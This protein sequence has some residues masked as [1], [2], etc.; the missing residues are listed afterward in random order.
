MILSV[1]TEV[2]HERKLAAVENE[3]IFVNKDHKLYI[4]AEEDEQSMARYIND[5]NKEKPNARPKMYTD[6][7]GKK[8]NQIVCERKI[9]V[10]AEF[11]YDYNNTYMPWRLGSGKRRKLTS[12]QSESRYLHTGG[13][14]QIPK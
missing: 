9:E 11:I 6:R 8:H 5:C 3:Y 13:N 10:E 1:F 12:N 4:D 2:D 7:S 14:M